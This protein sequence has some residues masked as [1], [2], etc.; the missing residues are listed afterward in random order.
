M[1]KDYY[2]ILG[3]SK[4]A[5]Q[6]EVKAA[7]RRLAHQHHPDKTGGDDK[8][9]KE[10]NEA[11]QVLGDPDKRAKYDQFG[12]AA[13]DGSAGFG[14]GQGFGGFDFSGFQNAGGFEDLGDLFG[15]MFG[16]RGGGRAGQTRG[17]DI[18]VDADL[19]FYESVFGVDKDIEV[20]KNAACE[21]CAGT[22]GEPGAGMKTC[23]ACKG[24]GVQVTVQRTVLGAIQSKRTCSACQGTGEI[25]NKICTTC[26]G[27]GVERKRER[28]SV[29][30]PAG[31]DDGAVLR[32]AGKGEAVRGGRTGDLFVRL[33]VKP[34]RRFERDGIHIHSSATIGF[35]QAALGDTIEIETVDGKGDLKIPAGTQSG[36]QFRLRGKGVPSNRGRGDQIV[37]VEVRTPERLSREQKKLLE[38]LDLRS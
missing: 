2:H 10:A 33:H 6:D 28:L 34:D 9:F 4:S 30:I 26:H 25:P 23:D 19:T 12:S 27:E 16:G 18:Q 14:G 1:S 5:S 31:V 35:T 3:I 21:R 11:Y 8:K 32:V 20:T 37:T 24:S 13:F 22:G 29:G 36:S 38:Q 15:D 7:F 17:S